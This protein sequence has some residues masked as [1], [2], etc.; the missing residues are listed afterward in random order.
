MRKFFLVSAAVLLGLAAG[1]IIFQYSPSLAALGGGSG[2]LFLPPYPDLCARF[3]FNGSPSGYD[4]GQLNA[5]WYSD[6]YARVDPP[7]PADLTYAQLIRFKAGDDPHDPSQVTVRPDR[8]TIAQIAEANPGSLWLLGNEPDSEYQGEP[9]FPETYAHV[10]HEF[11][12]YI[13]EQ[14]P[15]AVIGNGGIVQPT[16]CRMAYLDIVWDTY[17]LAYGEAM[18]VDV[19][20]IHAFVLREVQGDWGAS[21]PPGVDPSCGIDYPVRDA[22][23][24]EIFRNNLIAFRQWME[25]KGEQ[26]KPLIISEYG[27]LWPDWFKDEDGYGFPASRVNAFMTA[28]FDLYLNESYPSVGYPADGGRLV[29]AWAWYSVSDDSYNGNLFYSGHDILTSMGRNYAN[30]TNDLCYGPTETPTPT[31]TSTPT[32][33][34]TPTCTPTETSTP[35]PTATATPTPTA[36]DTPTPTPTLTP[37]STPTN[38]LDVPLQGFASGGD[39]VT[40]TVSA[41]E[42]SVFTG[43]AIIEL[44]GGGDLDGPDKYFELYIDGHQ[45]NGQYRSHHHDCTLHRVDAEVDIGPYIAGKEEFEVRVE[46]SPATSAGSPGCPDTAMK[47]LVRLELRDGAPQFEIYLPLIVEER[48]GSARLTGGG[49]DGR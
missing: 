22:D 46:S 3:G 21:T 20:N 13:K 7:R 36:T 39:V 23:N 29:Q 5:G 2:D 4:V 37:T 16:P 41:A 25:G 45:I 15:T 12:T 30:Y 19:W 1:V 42:G 28:T 32:E 43:G 8:A 27:I 6:W 9:I 44:C 24:I 11:Y 26:D 33:T 40:Q 48:S 49:H 10:Y 35:T 18:P 17:E 38:E 47:V 14:D 31:E 34:T